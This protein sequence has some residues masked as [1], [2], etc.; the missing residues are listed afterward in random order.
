MG[1][2][3]LSGKSSAVSSAQDLYPFGK[4]PSILLLKPGI[5]KGHRL[6]DAS[7]KK[8]ALCADSQ[9]MATQREG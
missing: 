1:K 5:P 9:V 8:N 6:G 4:L 7:W 2:L 3:S